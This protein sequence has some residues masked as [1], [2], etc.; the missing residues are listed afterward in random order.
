MSPDESPS[1]QPGKTCM[2]KLSFEP[3]FPETNYCDYFTVHHLF[4]IQL[5]ICS[6]GKTKSKIKCL[7]HRIK[8]INLYI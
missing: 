4:G 6:L 8:L 2:F 1:V 7:L 3:T 5:K